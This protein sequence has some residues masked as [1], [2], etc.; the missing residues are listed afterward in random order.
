VAVIAMIVTN[1]VALT[2]FALFVA[3]PVVLLSTGQRPR[4]GAVVAAL[5]SV[6]LVAMMF[7]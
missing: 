2:L 5:A 7:A 1:S 3:Y 4:G 6:A